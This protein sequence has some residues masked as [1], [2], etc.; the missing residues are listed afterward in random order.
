TGPGK[1]DSRFAGGSRR[2]NPIVIGRNYTPFRCNCGLADGL[3]KP[4]WRSVRYP[5]SI[6]RKIAFSLRCSAAILLQLSPRAEAHPAASL[7]REH[8]RIR[9]QTVRQEQF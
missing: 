3:M 6:P 8:N 1:N 7:D 2:S 5:G 9:F 4:V